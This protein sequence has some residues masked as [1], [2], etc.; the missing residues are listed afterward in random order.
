M[1]MQIL[2]LMGFEPSHWNKINIHIGGVYGDKLTTLDRFAVGFGRLTDNCKARLTV[3]N[4]DWISGFSVKDL[5]PLSLQCNIPIVFDFHHH[6]FCPGEVPQALIDQLSNML[7]CC[8]QQTLFLCVCV[9]RPSASLGRSSLHQGMSLFHH[10]APH[11]AAHVT[12]HVA[13]HVAVHVLSCW[14]CLLQSSVIRKTIM[15]SSCKG[16]P[17]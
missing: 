16:R 3:E 5:L 6:R 17:T 9:L 7:A 2:D 11:V 13:V 4:D 12:V 1:P 10:H 14:H 15:S 8:I